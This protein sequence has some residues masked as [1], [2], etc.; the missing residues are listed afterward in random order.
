MGTGNLTH[1]TVLLRS[2]S[3]E[4]NW[5]DLLEPADN[6]QV[7]KPALELDSF[8]PVVMYWDLNIACKTDLSEKN[9]PDTS[10]YNEHYIWYN[11]I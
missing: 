10:N 11:A 7:A 2:Q 3:T 1:Q 6:A 4:G 5:N 8:F 9:Q